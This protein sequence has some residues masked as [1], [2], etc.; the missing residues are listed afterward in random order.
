MPTIREAAAVFLSK[1]RIAVTGVSRNPG[2]HGSNVIYDRL[3]DRGYEVYAVNPYAESI[4]GDVCYPSLSAIPGGVEAVVIATNPGRAMA[5]MEECVSLGVDHVWMHRSFG[6][7]S[8]S[9]DAATWG[10]ANGI[11][12]IDGGCPLMFDPVSDR[13]HKAMKVLFTIMG[14]VPKEV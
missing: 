12:V 3:K 14:K 1:Q 7:G 13:A 8:V 5:T 2:S 11:E 4:N 6:D 10:R 9:K